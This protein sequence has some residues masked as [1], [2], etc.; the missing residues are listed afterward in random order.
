MHDPLTQAF[1][2]YRL[3]LPPDPDDVEPDDTLFDARGVCAD[4]GIPEST[5][6]QLDPEEYSLVS[7][8]AEPPLINLAGLASL[9]LNADIPAARLPGLRRGYDAVAAR[10]VPY[11]AK[12]LP[13]VDVGV[14]AAEYCDG[15]GCQFVFGTLG[16]A[17]KD[18]GRAVVRAI[19][20]RLPGLQA[21]ELGFGHAGHTWAL[22]VRPEVWP[23][24]PAGTADAALEHWRADVYSAAAAVWRA[25][26]GPA[27]QAGGANALQ[28]MVEPEAQ[29]FFHLT[30]PLLSVG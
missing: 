5:L 4:L 8:E 21:V 17:K 9:L 13:G 18:R 16:Y 22:L 23:L 1:A 12:V 27:A 26:D 30:D 19:R 24:A 25:A 3:D 28:A 15:R 10:F 29:F 6:A 11:A 14:F 20:D 2:R 7:G